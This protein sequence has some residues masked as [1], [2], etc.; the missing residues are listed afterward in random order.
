MSNSNEKRNK[1]IESLK[2]EYDLARHE[3]EY[4]TDLFNKQD[5]LYSIYFAIFAVIIAAIYY[6]I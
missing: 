3:W 5:N 6:I 4:Y 1:I 2:S